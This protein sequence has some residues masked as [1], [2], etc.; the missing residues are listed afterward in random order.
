MRW[1]QRALRSPNHPFPCPP[2]RNL[3][4]MTRS[5]TCFSISVP[6]RSRIWSGATAPSRRMCSIRRTWI[7]TSGAGSRSRR[8]PAGSSLRPNTTMDFVSGPPGILRIPSG[9]A[10][11]AMGKA[12]CC[13]NF[14]PPARRHG[15]KFGLYLSPWDRSHPQYGTGAGCAAQRYPETR[16]MPTARTGYRQN[17]T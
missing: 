12:T 11:G 6:I 8:V 7:V 4:G 17:A 15:L 1:R 10:S 2:R 13:A 16:A 3:P 5:S 14:P 9:K